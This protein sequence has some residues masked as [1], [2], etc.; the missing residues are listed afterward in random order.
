MASR[1]FALLDRD[2]T[3]IVNEPYLADPEGV[4]LIEGAATGLRRL[5]ALG[6]GVVIVTNQSAIGRELL[7]ERGLE[8]IHRRLIERLDAEGVH[9]EGIFHC[10]HHPDEGCPCRKPERGLVDRAA[11]VFGFD[12]ARC[13]VVGDSESDVAL[14]LGLNATAILVRTGHGA[15][16]EARGVSCDHVVDDLE[17]ASRLIENLLQA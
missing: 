16:T 12:P 17:A 4:V 15:E 8:A 7:D 13:F 3:V 11:A 14:G 9:V 10:P 1:R 2:G 5:A 6:L